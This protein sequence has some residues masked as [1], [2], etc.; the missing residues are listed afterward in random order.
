MPGIK[1][2]CYIIEALLQSDLR[3]FYD[4]T[5]INQ[6]QSYLRLTPPINIT[7]LEK[8]LPSNFSSNSSIA[9]LLDHLMVEQWTP[10]I[11]YEKYYHECQ[12]YQCVYIYKTKNG[13]IGI[14]TI[15]IGLI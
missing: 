10:L 4:Q 14:I 12:P 3:C 11:V 15:I 5:C 9:E 8:S 13:A 2:G 1:S 6:L 7:A